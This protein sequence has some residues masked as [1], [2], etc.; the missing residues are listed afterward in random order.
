VDDSQSR[1]Y[2]THQ[3]LPANGRWRS[4]EKLNIRAY[5]YAQ[6]IGYNEA[7]KPGLGSAIFLHLDSGRPTAGCV[8]VPRAAL[9]ALL[10]WQRAGAVMAIT[11]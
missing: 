4:A 6:I 1:L 9:L 7:R 2:N 8:S 10:R 11:G 3:V 5:E